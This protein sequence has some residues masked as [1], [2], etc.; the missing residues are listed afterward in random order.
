MFIFMGRLDLDSCQEDEMHEQNHRG[1]WVD[2][3]GAGRKKD[4]TEVICGV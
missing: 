4:T 1:R 2:R 3:K